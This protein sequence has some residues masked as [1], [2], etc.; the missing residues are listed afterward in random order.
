M[1]QDFEQLVA[2]LPQP[3]QHFRLYVAGN[4]HRS[5]E[6]VNNVRR[7][8]E[9]YLP[10]RYQLEVVDVYQQPTA[11]REA[12]LIA[13]PTLIRHLPGPLKRFVGNMSDT[14]RI[15]T[16]LGMGSEIL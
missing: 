9:Q 16:G 10:N 11:T 13:L 5:S 8:C 6:A 12:D 15:L 2:N 1:P 7:F 4:T 14:K 3:V